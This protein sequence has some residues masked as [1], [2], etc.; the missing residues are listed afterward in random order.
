MLSVCRESRSVALKKFKLCLGTP[1]VYADFSGGDILYFGPLWGNHGRVL[2]RFGQ[3]S[4][5]WSNPALVSEIKQISR[6]ALRNTIW[7]FYSSPED[8]NRNG[9]S[10]R[11]DVHYSFPNLKELFLINGG[12][13]SDFAKTPGHI[14]FEERPD[15]YIRNPPTTCDWRVYGFAYDVREKFMMLDYE[16]DKRVWFDGIPEVKLVAEKRTPNIPGDD[17]DRDKGEPFV[18]T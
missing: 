4:E 14:V 1:N 17:W 8:G 3:L 15:L 13:G 16:P 7:R 2:G 11:Y 9:H 18:S 12:P 5:V 10:L 6:V